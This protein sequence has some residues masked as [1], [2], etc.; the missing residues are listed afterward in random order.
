MCMS[1][2]R[3]R[4]MFRCCCGRVSFA[5]VGGGSVMVAVAAGAGTERIAESRN[6]LV[7][8]R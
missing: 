1:G 5:S 8:K 2:Q 7:T 4:G 3:G 6:T